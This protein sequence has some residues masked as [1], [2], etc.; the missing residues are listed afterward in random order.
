MNLTIK[1]ESGEVICSIFIMEK[2]SWNKFN[3]AD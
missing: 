1:T 3:N 2:G